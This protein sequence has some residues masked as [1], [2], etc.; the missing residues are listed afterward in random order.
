MGIELPKSRI[1]LRQI[2]TQKRNI[3]IDQIINI[4]GYN[5]WA[6]GIE[7]AGNVIG[8]A[9]TKRAELRRQG[10]QLARMEDLGGLPKG[11][12]SGLDPSQAAPF[13]AAGMK[14]RTDIEEEARKLIKN[15][16]R[17]SSLE[18]QFGYA[19]GSLGEEPE[20][21]KLKVNSDQQEARML[22]L[23]E[24]QEKQEQVKNETKSR[25]DLDV[26]TDTASKALQAI[27]KIRTAAFEIP[28]IK[29]GFFSQSVGKVGAALKS[30]SKDPKI[31]FYQ[32]VVSQE[33]IP[34]ARSLAEEKGPITDLDV[35]RI[36]KGLGDITTPMDTRNALLNELVNKI[37]LGISNKSQTSG[38]PESDILSRNTSLA[39][40]LRQQK[41]FQ[42]KKIDQ[43]GKADFRW[44]PQTGQLEPN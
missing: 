30:Y 14:Q 40:L 5:P 4:E 18:T 33:L 31:S 21:A 2:Q 1:A 37:E 34:L 23:F 3:P 41:Q 7:T 44:N 8:Q 35:A 36:E 17:V 28:D 43:G 9:I 25:W 20:A 15:R 6:K 29:P 11:S 12:L 16:E 19:K 22:K 24:L 38:I 39:G 26:Y 27:S 13:S 42:L 10:E 32:G